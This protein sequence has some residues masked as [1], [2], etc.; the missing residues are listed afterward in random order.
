MTEGKNRDDF[1]GGLGMARRREA[2]VRR[3]EEAAAAIAALAQVSEIFYHEQGLCGIAVVD[4]RHIYVPRPTTRRTALCLR[5]RMR[6]RRPRP[7]R[8]KADPP[9]GVR[10]GEVGDLGPPVARGSRRQEV[11]RRWKAARR[12][13]TWPSGGERSGSTGNSTASARTSFHVRSSGGSPRAESSRT[14]GLLD[15]PVRQ[16]RVHRV[17]LRSGSKSNFCTRV[18]TASRPRSCRPRGRD[19][20]RGSWSPSGLPDGSA[21]CDST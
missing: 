21:D 2:A 5:P 8:F 20:P 11:G 9:S 12:R 1:A 17:S 6:A 7:R 10:G 14:S 16:G 19:D 15:D 18:R 4:I 3:F 13:S